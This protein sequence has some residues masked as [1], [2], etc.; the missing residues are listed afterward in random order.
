MRTS[1]RGWAGPHGPYKEP[2]TP[3]STGTPFCGWSPLKLLKLMPKFGCHCGDVRNRGLQ[4]VIRSLKQGSMPFSWGCVSYLESELLHSEATS[5]V[6][7]LL[8][9]DIS[10]HLPPL[11][12]HQE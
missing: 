8:Y 12:A 4:E 10:L 3:K 2:N 5:L 1:P 7:S 6:P 11:G 9:V